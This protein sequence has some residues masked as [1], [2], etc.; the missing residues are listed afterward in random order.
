MMANAA[1]DPYW[2]AAVRR[3]VLERPRVSDVIQD[4]CSTCH[5]PMATVPAQ[6]RGEKG[7]IFAHLPVGQ[8]AAPESALAADGVSCSICHQIQP[9]RLGEPS[10]LT[11]GFVIDARKPWGQRVVFGRFDVDAGRTRVMHSASQMRP[12]RGLHVERSELCA[13]CHTLITRALDAQGKVVGRLPEQVPY[14]EW[15]HSSYRDSRSCQ[16]CHMPV[17]AGESPIASVVGQAQDRSSPSRFRGRQ[18]LSGPSVHPVCPRARRER[19]AAGALARHP[20]HASNTWRAQV[21]TSHWSARRLRMASSGA[22]C[23]CPTW[24]ATS[25]PPPIPPVARGSIWSCSTAAVS[26]CSNRAD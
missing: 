25:C 6:A 23:R 10:S 9:D 4:E 16:S 7:S 14:Q 18:L 13:T 15:L 5:M 2:H 26:P 21:R 20:S 24:P 12:T 19:H 17:I 8:A 22:P 11:G 3:E 1:R